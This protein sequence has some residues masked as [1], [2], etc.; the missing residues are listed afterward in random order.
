[1]FTEYFRSLIPSGIIV[2]IGWIMT[3]AVAVN[4]PEIA[5]LMIVLTFALGLTA[6][7]MMF[8]RNHPEFFS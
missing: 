3:S 2:F 7:L 6:W 5:P 1:M 4:Y 8:K